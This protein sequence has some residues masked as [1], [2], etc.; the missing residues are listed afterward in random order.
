[1]T[2]TELIDWLRLSLSENVGPTTFR[3]L[4]SFFGSATEALA[5]VGELAKRGG[6][7]AI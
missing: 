1:M 4:L 3:Q 5:H 7:R 6:K 2:N